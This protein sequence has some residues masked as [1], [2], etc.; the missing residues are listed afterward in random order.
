[1][2]SRSRLTAT[3]GTI[4]GSVIHAAAITA[5]AFGNLAYAAAAGAAETPTEP[6]AADAQLSAAELE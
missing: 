5:M 4:L 2:P 1:M 6:A 3:L